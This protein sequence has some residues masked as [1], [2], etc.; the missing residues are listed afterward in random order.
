VEVWPESLARGG[1][2]PTMPLWLA[3]DLCVPLD[4]EASYIA[5]C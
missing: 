3:L 2:L 5:A 4:L 1:D